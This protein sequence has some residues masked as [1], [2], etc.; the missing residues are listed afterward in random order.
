M[1]R[2]EIINR[3]RRDHWQTQ[4]VRQAGE[5]QPGAG[6]GQPDVQPVGKQGLEL[7]QTPAG[8]ISLGRGDGYQ[9]GEVH[10]KL[11]Q[12]ANRFAAGRGPIPC[13]F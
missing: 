12:G 8:R 6:V 4:A 7:R 1:L 10:G 2:F 13:V 5:R 3:G 11:F 9:P